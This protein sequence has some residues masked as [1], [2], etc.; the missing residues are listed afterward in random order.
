MLGD[1][2]TEDEWRLSVRRLVLQREQREYQSFREL[3]DLNTALS[4][5]VKLLKQ[6]LEDSRAFVHLDDADGDTQDTTGLDEDGSPAGSRN[7]RASSTSSVDSTGS[8]RR[9]SS[10]RN[11]L[12]MARMKQR[13]K[14]MSAQ[15]Q[16]AQLREVE[17]N[18]MRA[19]VLEAEAQTKLMDQRHEQALLA[20]KNQERFILTQKK[21][22]QTKTASLELL[23]KQIKANN[24]Q[25]LKNETNIRQLV[26]E[27]EKV[28]ARLIA[29]K[30]KMQVA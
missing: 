30:A 7:E 22:L 25:I 24:D 19:R 27:N 15:L 9:S 23:Q 12:G 10:S 16:S 6:Q 11:T 1:T 14:A 29:D 4:A 2:A 13:L 17:Y 21:E 26:G 18:R 28:V 5:E 8:L 20:I 3:V